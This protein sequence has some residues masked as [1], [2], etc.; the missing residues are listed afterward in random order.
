M[1]KLLDE[2]WSCLTN[3]EA[4]WWMTKLLDEWWSCLEND[5]AAWRMMKLLGKWRR[6]LTNDEA[7]WRLNDSL[8]LPGGGRARER[9]SIPRLK[10]RQRRPGSNRWAPI[11][12]KINNRWAR[13]IFR[14]SNRWAQIKFRISTRRAGI[15]FIISI[16]WAQII[17]RISNGWTQIIF[18]I[19]TKYKTNSN[20]DGWEYGLDCMKSVFQ[21][22]ANWCKK[23]KTILVCSIQIFSLG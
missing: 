3:D 2:W 7:A 20:P 18:W 21:K 10:S 12:F 17:F 11:I 1:T 8:C 13:I 15:I 9:T 14:I 6:R 19:R 23:E 16:R 4:A 5:E 22:S